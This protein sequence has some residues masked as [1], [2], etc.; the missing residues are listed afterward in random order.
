VATKYLSNY[1]HWFEFIDTVAKGKTRQT[2]R[3]ALLLGA[4]SV[5]VV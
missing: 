1:L 5:K 4:C 3:R 2:A